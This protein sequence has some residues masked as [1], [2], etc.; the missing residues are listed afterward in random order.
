MELQLVEFVNDS[1]ETIKGK[2]I[3]GLYV[4]ENVNGYKAQKFFL[5][6]GIELP[7]GTN[8]NDMLDVSFN[9]K[10]RIEKISKL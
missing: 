2:N 5:K 3:Y 7:K 4:D 6:E 9:V 8:L 10:G 1:K